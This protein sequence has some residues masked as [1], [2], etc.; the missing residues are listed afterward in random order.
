MLY[1]TET[2]Y[3]YARV[4]ESADGTRKLELNEGQAIHSLWRPGTVLTGGYWDGFLVLPFAT[5]SGEPPARIA[6]LGTRGR[7][8]PARATRTTSRTR[9]IDAVDI[10]PELFEIGRRYFGLKPRP[11][12]REF[13][14]GRAAV[15]ARDARSATTRSSST[16]TASPTSPST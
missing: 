8:G 16:P 14:A 15:P 9:A 7:D 3:Q 1:E 12:L 10:D 6:V 11:Q 5:G 2:P 4:V 13:A